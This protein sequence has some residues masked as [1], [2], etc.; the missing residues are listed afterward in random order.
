LASAGGAIMKV[1]GVSTTFEKINQINQEYIREPLTTYELVQGE[2]NK[3]GP[4]AFFDPNVWS[5]A[6][7]GAQDISYGQ[8]YVNKYRMSYDPKFNIYNPA[9]REAAFNKSAW[10]KWTSGAIDLGIQLVGDVTLAAGKAGKVL[11]ASELGTGV[12]KNADAVAQAAE[13]ITKAQYGVKNRFTKVLDDFTANDSAYAI[14]HP[15]VKSSS[16]PGLLAY[17]LGQSKNVDETSLVLRSAMGDP[18]AMDELASVRI[19][20]TDALQAARGDLSAVD[21]FK[22]FNAPNDS[23]MIRFLN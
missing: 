21:E 19:D 10:G 5:K 17:M 13:D 9:E 4:L 16:Q 6:Y 18:A 22:L 1:P 7:K 14:N 3:T 15:M 20:L 8:A 11:K 23:G 12:L 2:V